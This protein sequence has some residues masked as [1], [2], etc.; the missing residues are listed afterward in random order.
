MWYQRQK[1]D[2]YPANCVVF[3]RNFEFQSDRHRR[4]RF[5]AVRGSK[6]INYYFYCCFLNCKVCGTVAL[7]KST[8]WLHRWK[9][10]D[11]LIIQRGIRVWRWYYGMLSHAISMGPFMGYFS[12]FYCQNGNKACCQN[13]LSDWRTLKQ[14]VCLIGKWRNWRN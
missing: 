14:I 1:I 2:S 8:I 12:Q 6:N 4:R 11:F 3:G 7:Q 13:A 10:I 5:I 9:G